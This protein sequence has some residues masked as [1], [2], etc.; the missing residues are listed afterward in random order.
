MAYGQESAVGKGASIISI[1]G[2]YS[3]ENGRVYTNSNPTTGSGTTTYSVSVTSLA[4]TFNHFFL[5]NFFIGAGLG[6]SSQSQ[7]NMSI[8]SIGVGPQLGFAIGDENSSAFPF[9]DIGF[10]YYNSEANLGSQGYSSGSAKDIFIGFGL[11]IPIKTHIGFTLEGGYH[12]LNYSD[13]STSGKMFALGAGIV[14]LFF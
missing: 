10:R 1:Q 2:S 9:F 6:Y 14:G 8:S 13:A 12:M 5:D 7:S 4:G 11:V 3:S